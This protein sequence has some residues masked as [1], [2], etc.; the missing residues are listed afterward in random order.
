MTQARCLPRGH[1]TNDL[2]VSAGSPLIA[3]TIDR[4]ACKN[5]LVLAHTYWAWL[6]RFYTPTFSI[7][8][9][10]ETAAFLITFRF[11]LPAAADWVLMPVT[12]SRGTESGRCDRWQGCA[13]WISCAT[14]V[15]GG[16]FWFTEQRDLRE[17]RR[18]TTAN[19]SVRRDES[20]AH[21]PQAFH[22][23]AALCWSIAGW[24]PGRQASMAGVAF[25]DETWRLFIRHPLLGMDLLGPSTGATGL[26]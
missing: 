12:P 20:G 15:M 5:A 22:R 21:L 17:P 3:T 24:I 18:P 8:P 7:A 19:T 4:Q 11:S 6:H 16:R 1:G 13:D 9:V 23:A 26:R 14:P 25:S 10:A 2:A